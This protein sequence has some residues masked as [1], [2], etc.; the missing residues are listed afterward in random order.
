LLDGISHRK[1]DETLD[2]AATL[3]KLSEASQAVLDQSAEKIKL[4]EEGNASAVPELQGFISKLIAGLQPLQSTLQDR[5]DKVTGH[6]ATARQGAAKQAYRELDEL[7]NTV[8]TAI[9][10]K[11]SE[12]G[13][14][15]DALIAQLVPEDSVDAE[16]FVDLVSGLK[17]VSVSKEQAKNVLEHIAGGSE[18]VVSKDRFVEYTRLYYKCVKGTPMSE[19][20]DI[21]SKSLRRLEVGEVCELLEGPIQEEEIGVQRVKCKAMLD[22]TC[23]WV[24][25]A[26]NQGTVFLV[27]GGNLYT[28]VKELDMLSTSDKESATLVRKVEKGEVV[29][30]LEF[31]S[32]SMETKRIRG[33]AKLDGVEGWMTVMDQGELFL[34]QQ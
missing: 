26:G 28:C 14:S 12:D 16:K 4:L 25:T 31:S 7:S 24:T 18:K 29:Q 11:L 32:A 17:T 30:V 1:S 15:L 19:E 3:E 20:S 33:R 21:K 13:T 22:G 6:L 2:L 34:E 23:G 10:S 5:T 27:P 8:A 9:R